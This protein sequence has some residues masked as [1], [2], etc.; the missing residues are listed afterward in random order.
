ML[1]GTTLKRRIAGF[2]SVVVVGL[3]CAAAVTPASLL[4]TATGS[5]FPVR[6]GFGP[7]LS[8][9]HAVREQLSRRRALLSSLET[10][11][12]ALEVEVEDLDRRHAHAIAELQDNR[13]E[14]AM[15]ERR[16][17]HLVPR[18]LARDA[19]VRERR[20]QVGRLLGDLARSSRRVELDQTIRAR[21]L[22]ISPVML[23]R[24]RNAEARLATIEQ[25]PA[26]ALARRTEIEHRVPTL[27]AEAR[28]LQQ[29][30]E[31]RARERLATRM[32]LDEVG[33][34]VAR[35]D[36]EQRFL[37]QQV[38]TVEAAHDA[39]IGQRADQPAL[40]DAGRA[41]ASGIFAAAVKGQLPSPP[42]ASLEA[43]ARQ[44][45]TSGVLAAAAGSMDLPHA[46]A[47]ARLDLPAMSP[48][49]AKPIDVALKGDVAPAAGWPGDY[50]GV[51]P[52]DVV[53]L[54]PAPLADVGSRVAAARLRRAQPPLM[55]VPD[56]MMNPFSD[57]AGA[58]A[59]PDITI[60]AAPGQPVA[61]PEAGRVVFAG[62]FRSYG[63]LLIIE[64][65]R[66]YHTLLWGFSKLDVA[67]GDRV[68][69][70]QVVGVMA[71][72]AARTPA[73]HVELRHN[74]R[75]VNPLPWLAAS[76][77]KVRG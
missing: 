18:M 12:V 69:T 40:L 55:P 50:P 7:E 35:L 6:D 34:E 30:G 39:R 70:G 54:E 1:R 56:E 62:T 49:P 29:Q 73:L 47:T 67:K 32:R 37:S 72:D 17:D 38:L 76:S 20:E 28:R 36:H 33:G 41:A 58:A 5:G 74:G 68:R 14:V 21:L 64:H 24:L 61:T 46:L 53:F 51:T 44:P 75:P 22:A 25:Q 19:A 9:L 45:V 60:S 3:A 4:A 8:R 57:R 77:N 2:A 31:Q 16:L 13:A 48:P 10:R 59:E 63:N 23:R 43:D 65:Q 66:E 71:D 27:V 11:V 42:R 26:A 15:I 52:L